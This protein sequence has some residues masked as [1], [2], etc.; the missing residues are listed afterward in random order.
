MAERAGKAVRLWTAE[1]AFGDREFS[2]T[3]LSNPRHLQLRTSH[4]LWH[5]ERS[6]NLLLQRVLS[7]HA[8]AEY[9]AFVDADISFIRHD[10]ADET[11]HALQHYDVVQ[12]WRE[13]YDLDYH[14][15]VIQKHVSF[16]ACRG[17]GVPLTSDDY[18]GKGPR[19]IYWH[20]GYAWAWRRRA[21]DSVGGLIDWAVLGS[22]D[23]HMAHGLVGQM[24]HT[25]KR[26]LGGVY[27]NAMRRWQH[28]A[29]R[30]VKHNVGCLSGSIFH[31]FHGPKSSRKYKTRWKILEETQFDQNQDLVAD[32]QGLY[33]FQ[34]HGTERSD[35]LRDLTRNY[36][37]QRNEDAQ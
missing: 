22:A 12:M 9:I 10:W 30:G 34:H 36:F 8:E 23:F 7:Q 4:E 6:Q 3:G 27:K 29:E 19:T 21:L 17:D 15:N 5:K 1:I 14:G 13:A 28:R 31:H 33:Q 25:L 20:P 11:R 26:N 35:K 16:A 18:Y 24:E 32:V 37:H 2:I